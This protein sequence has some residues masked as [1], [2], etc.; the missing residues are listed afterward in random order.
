MEYI[1]LYSAT[2]VDKCEKNFCS[3]QFFYRPTRTSLVI[4]KKLPN[5]FC[6]TKK[7]AEITW[8]IP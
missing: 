4:N 2:S 6:S 8:Y 3:F 5:F 7:K 1:Q